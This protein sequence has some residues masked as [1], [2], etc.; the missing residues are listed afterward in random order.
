MASGKWERLSALFELT[1]DKGPDGTM[2]GLR[3]AYTRNQKQI[4]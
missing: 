1:I 3:E 2:D 4:Y